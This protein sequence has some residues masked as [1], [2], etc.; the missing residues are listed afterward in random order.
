M[1]TVSFRCER[2]SASGSVLKIQGSTATIFNTSFIDC[3][4]IS[5]GG[6]VQSYDNASVDITSSNFR[7]IHSFGYGGAISAFGSQVRIRSSS[8]YNCTSSSGG[9]AIWAA[10]FESCYGSL[11]SINTTVIIESSS[12]LACSSSGG[13]GGIL[14]SSIF[15]NA[16]SVILSTTNS[17]FINCTSWFEGGAIKISG[18]LVG[19]DISSSVFQNCRSSLM[20]GAISVSKQA[21]LSVVS[22]RFEGNG[23]EG[24]GGGALHMN[25]ADI[26]SSNSVFVNNSAA[27]G[28]GGVLYWQ[29]RSCNSVSQDQICKF[30]DS[31][32]TALYGA[33]IASEYK[34]LIASILSD[35]MFPGLEFFMSII[36][37]DAYNQSIESDDDSVIQAYAEQDGSEIIIG[38]SIFKLKK[39]QANV[40]IAI[41]PWFSNISFEKG[42]ANLASVPY[43]FFKG[44]DSQNLS[45]LMVSSY[46]PLIFSAGEHVCPPGYVIQIE[47]QYLMSGPAVCSFCNPGK[48]SVM[49]LASTPG[50]LTGAPSCLNCP[51]GGNCINGGNQVQFQV[52]TWIIS[53]EGIYALSSCPAG[54]QLVNYSNLAAGVTRKFSHD[55]Q[56]CLAC[57]PGLQYILNP[58]TD[59]C[60]ICPPGLTCFGTDLIH[61]NIPNSKWIRNGSVYI[62][63]T[64]PTGYQIFNL[65]S[66]GTFDATVQQCIPCD[67]GKECLLSACVQCT[68]CQTG[69]YKS[70]ADI[71][72]CVAC[73]SDSYGLSVG[74]TQLTQCLPC[75]PHSTTLGKTGVNTVFDCVCLQQYYQVLTKNSIECRLCPSGAVCPYDGTCAL[76][77]APLFNCSGSTHIVGN[78]SLENF[79][80]TLVGC[81]SGYSLNSQAE[82]CNLCPASFYCEGGTFPSAPCG[83]GFYSM[84]GTNSSAFCS[85]SVFVIVTM[86]VNIVRPEFT[87]SSA[88]LFQKTL[89]YVVG[90]SPEYVS[91]T[92]VVQSLDGLSTVVTSN[93]AFSNAGDADLLANS[94]LNQNQANFNLGFK[95][96]DGCNLLTVQLTACIPGFELISQTCHMCPQNRFCVGGSVGSQICP[97]GTYSPSGSNSSNSCKPAI[98]VLISVSLPLSKDNFTNQMQNRLRS[99]LALTGTVD[100]MRVSILAITQAASQARRFAGSPSLVNCEIATD[101]VRAAAEISSKFDETD[102]NANL[103]LQGLPSCS[104]INVAV[105]DETQRSSGTVSL[106]LVIGV[107]VGCFIFVLIS[108]GVGY[109]MLVVIWRQRAH[110]TFLCAFMNATPG[111]RAFPKNLPL[112]LLKRYNA[113]KILGKGA[114]GCVVLA[115]NKESSK[116]VA[117][118]LI[119]PQRNV[120]DT[121]EIRQMKREA[122]VLE[123]YTSKKCEDA[124]NLAGVDAVQVRLDVCWFITEFLEG[125]N[126][127]VIIYN[128]VRKGEDQLS[129][130]SDTPNYNPIGH[131]ECIKVTRSTLAALKIIHAEGV[132]HRDIKPANIVR[133]N[134]EKPGQIWDGHSFRYKL[135]DFGTALGVDETVAKEVMMTL[136][137][138]RNMGA[139]TPPYMSPEMF[140]EPD[141]AI[142]PSDLW[143]LGVT[144]FEI[145]TSSLPFEAESEL[146]WSIAIAGNMDAKAPNVLDKLHSENRSKFNNNLAKVI[147]KALEKKVEERYGS[148]DEMHDAVYRCLIDQGEAFYSVFIS[149]RVA[150]E[151]P[152]ARFLFDELNHSTTPGGH[153][154]TVYW[155]AHRL[156]KG[157]DWEDGFA[158][159]LL[160]SL[161]IFPLLSYGSTAPLAALSEHSLADAVA[162]GWEEMPLG[163]RR[164]QGI[165]SDW[166]DNV[167]KEILIAGALLEKNAVHQKQGQG[168]LQVAYPILIGRQQPEGHPDYPRMGNFFQVQGG[169]G[170]YP[171]RPSP[172]T[173]RAV[174]SFL[175]CKAGFSQERICSVEERS[176]EAAISC[177]T[178]LQ[179]CQMWNHPEDLAEEQ[180]SREQESLLGMGYG[181]P[182]VDLNRVCLS[183]DQVNGRCCNID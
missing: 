60:Q 18:E 3:S 70:F 36:K 126:L 118:K 144:M 42:T 30:N 55:V 68:L 100:V 172:P 106:P 43:I 96:F 13:G 145:V 38:D 16:E 183:P 89:A 150:S 54:Y 28:G 113:E 138:N 12:F 50:S 173:N 149:Y 62:L 109:V 32:N 159:G 95:E 41:K 131:G 98:F 25:N 14:I 6:I 164:L 92:A 23:A 57:I 152:L 47:S 26:F 174:A 86:S 33:C 29:G 124:V 156:V 143:S 134:F 153:R 34:L 120:F 88:V 8:F 119:V 101:D 175:R 39:G 115:K 139:G 9:G 111:D 5:D 110:K 81:P 177:L 170:I 97:T 114:F 27:A 84:P 178:R 51:A 17:E 7:N 166:E 69:F 165:E 161:C 15:F 65:G 87:D 77:N 48:Y 90:K 20:G 163:R 181:G 116:L 61:D 140:K 53:N 45:H 125:D 169:G 22:S 108:T 104:L 2:S 76:R 74:S 146:L 157:Q 142:Y 137:G 56:E 99:A 128:H 155:D 182:P 73:P 133:C 10:S 122:G 151:L 147:S 4:S 129:D 11:R 1:V 24:L 52:G 44:L 112:Y 103:N 102:L 80:W 49:P 162:K 82:T 107:S 58:D 180:L 130:K 94:I 72:P 132:I 171:Q 167:L 85:A 46:I 141:K 168:I 59:T 105:S 64:C 63:T 66:K 179:G 67:A 160:N 31:G 176:V 79:I 127:D 93:I 19:A 21:R 78:W 154:I 91:V 40:K 71:H 117:I 83:A 75:P 35:V 121:K 37:K 123:L 136:V 135:I 148:V 158:T